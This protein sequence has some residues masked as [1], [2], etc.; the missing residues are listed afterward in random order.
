[1]REINRKINIFSNTSLK[2]FTLAEVLI[3]L[4]IIGVVAAIL[5]PTMMEKVQDW[6]FKQAA[7]EAFSK[8]S[9][10]IQ[11]MKLDEGG[12]LDYGPSNPKK[13]KDAVMPYFK[14]L[15]DCRVN[16]CVPGSYDSDVYASLSGEK[17]NTNVGAE[18]QFIT[19]DGMFYNIQDS[20]YSGVFIIVDV[21]GYAK[22]PNVYGKDTFM[23]QLKNNNLFPMGAPGTHYPENWKYC[24]KTDVKGNTS[25]QGIGCMYNVMQGKDY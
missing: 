22:K 19:A 7:K 11:Q 23:F 12:T 18:G 4:G 8:C 20:V 24:D 9:Q 14:I 5:I 16:G 13:F 15:K 25:L 2:A 10:V 17:A 21:N 6:Q 3:T 1:M